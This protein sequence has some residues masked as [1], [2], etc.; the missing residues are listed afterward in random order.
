MSQSMQAANATVGSV[1]TSISAINDAV[2]QVSQAVARTK[3]AAQVL[4]R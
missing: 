4:V 3:A 1:T 2:G